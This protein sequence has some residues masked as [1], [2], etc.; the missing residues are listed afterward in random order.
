M[1]E[2]PLDAAAVPLLEGKRDLRPAG[3]RLEGVEEGHRLPVVGPLG[4]CTYLGAFLLS[5]LSEARFPRPIALTASR[6]PDQPL[7]PIPQMAITLIPA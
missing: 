6:L 2:D 7:I 1:L 4:V 5:S 3:F